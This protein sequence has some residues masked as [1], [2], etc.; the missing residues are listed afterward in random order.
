MTR[1][2]DGRTIALAEG[3]QLEDL[4][5]MLEHEGAAIWRCPM[6]SIL[7]APDPAPVLAW[8]REL[9]A[10][11]FGYVVLLTGEGLRRLLGVAERADLREEVIAALGRTRLITRGPKPVRALKEVGLSPTKVA[12]SPTTL[13]V[14]ATLRT[15]PLQGQTVGV[16]LY[17]AANPPL[18]QFLESSGAQVAAVLPYVYAPAA[19]AERVAEL[20]HALDRGTI[21]VLVFTSSPQVDR[22]YEVAREHDLEA[23]LTRGL[24]HTRVAAVG[25]IVAD[26]LRRRN[27]PV[28][29]CP[30]QGFVMKNLVQH[31]KRDLDVT[32]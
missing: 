31:I 26:N 9:I 27:A 3:R 24:S 23:V 17:D 2:L 30:E 7:D 15:E 18:T 32:H 29:I 22:L 1:P 14:I 6:V 12:E 10:G 20:I 16:Q 11:R 4:A 13:G 21:H 5:Q 28:A 19:D 8:L 25:P